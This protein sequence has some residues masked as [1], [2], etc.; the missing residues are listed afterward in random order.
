MTVFK[1]INGKIVIIPSLYGRNNFDSFVVSNIL[2]GNVL[3]AD[4]KKA[5]KYVRPSELQLLR[6]NT[7]KGS[8]NKILTKETFVKR[9]VK[10]DQ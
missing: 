5:F 7:S 8:N 9:L 4:I 10:D 6:G 3:Y 2:Q 1:E